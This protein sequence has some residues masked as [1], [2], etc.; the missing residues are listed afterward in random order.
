M[1]HR[2]TI[3]RTPGTNVQNIKLSKK[4]CIPN[5]YLVRN[6]TWLLVRRIHLE[7]YRKYKNKVSCNLSTYM[8][9][10]LVIFLHAK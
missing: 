7:A 6:P 2:P 8:T 4:Y 5:D 1:Y 9:S 3:K 10:E